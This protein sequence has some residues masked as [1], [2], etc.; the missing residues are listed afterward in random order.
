[1]NSAALSSA[2]S[3]SQVLSSILHI[4]GTAEAEHVWASEVGRGTWQERAAIVPDAR[5]CF[6]RVFASQKPAANSR[7]LLYKHVQ[8]HWPRNN[9]TISNVHDRRGLCS[10]RGP[11]YLW[12]SHHIFRLSLLFAS[13][14]K[15]ISQVVKTFKAFL[16]IKKSLIKK[17]KKDY[18]LK[19]CSVTAR[20]V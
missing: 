9:L 20:R 16:L 11:I 5:C 12:T 4:S 3:R 14:A 17:K 6:L 2:K 1:M 19:K 13:Q 8:L 15:Q 18:W 10:A 7:K